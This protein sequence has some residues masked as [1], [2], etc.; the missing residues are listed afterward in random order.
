MAPYFSKKKKA[1]KYTEPQTESKE[2]NNRTYQVKSSTKARA[3]YPE[4]RGFRGWKWAHTGV[5]DVCA[6][7]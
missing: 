7:S 4:Q 3:V 5:R 1:F 6:G 2:R